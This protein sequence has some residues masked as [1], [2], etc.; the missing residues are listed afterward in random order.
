ML[1]RAYHAQCISGGFSRL[2]V[3]EG[4]DIAELLLMGQQWRS[5]EGG[6]NELWLDDAHAVWV[7]VI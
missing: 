5:G 4:G 6:S 3:A 7:L 2:L 1:G